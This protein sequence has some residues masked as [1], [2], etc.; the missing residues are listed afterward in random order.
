VN[1]HPAQALPGRITISP[2]VLTT[3]VAQT[4]L[5][6]EG[7]RALGP[8]PPRIAEA[9]GAR[10]SAPGVEAVVVDH[11]VYVALTVQ[12]AP[13]ANMMALASTLQ[14]EIARNIEHILGMQVARVDVHI[15][16]VAFP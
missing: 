15:G 7:V 8:R 9:K 16:D 1:A 5:D 4:A 6:T 14:Q 2:Q 3:I 11:T 13:D 12:V 10:A